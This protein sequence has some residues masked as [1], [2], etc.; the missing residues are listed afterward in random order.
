ML[1]K[2][3]LGSEKAMGFRWEGK[4][5][6]KGVKQSI[7]QFLP[8]LQSRAKMNVYVE[9]Q[10]ISEVEAKA[11]WDELKF[12]LKNFQQLTDKIDKIAVV[13]DETWLRTISEGS[14]IVLPGIKVKAF[15]M[16]EKQ[17]G[18]TWVTE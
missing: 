3:D 1:Q 18:T 6:E 16:A 10:E 11:L 4:F 17:A 2:I 9:I 13:T 7:L 14:S 12:D 8:E 5:D 15:T